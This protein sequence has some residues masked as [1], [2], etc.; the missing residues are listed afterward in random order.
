[1]PIPTFKKPEEKEKNFLEKLLYTDLDT[2]TLDQAWKEYRYLKKHGINKYLEE[3][4]RAEPGFMKEWEQRSPIGKILGRAENEQI[5]KEEEIALKAE[6][7]KE[8]KEKDII[9]PTGFVKTSGTVPKFE[10]KDEYTLGDEDLSEVGLGES[11]GHAIASFTIKIPLGFANLAAEISDLF[12]EEGLPVDQ[13]NVAKLNSW[14]ERTVL[15]DMM[16]YSEKKA[17]A[18]ATGRITEALGQLLGAYKTAG[19]TGIKIY[20]KGGEIAD[21]MIDAY[22]KKKYIKATGK[23]GKNMYK[24]AKKAKQLKKASYGRDFGAVAFGGLTTAAGIYDI[25]DIGT[26]GDIFFDEGEWTALDRREGEDADDDAARRLWNRLRFG[27]ELAFP[28][29]PIVYGGGKVAKMLATRGKDLAYSNSL[30]ERWV[31]KW[32]GQP[33]RARSKKPLEVAR[34]VRRQEGKEASARVLAED[35]LLDI[36][37]KTKAILKTIKPAAEGVEN[38]ELISKTLAKLLASGDD[39][40]TRGGINFKGFKNKDLETFYKSMDNLGI[41]KKPAKDLAS[42]LMGIRQSFTGFKNSILQGKNIAK[43]TSE[44]NEIMM[45][46]FTDNLTTDFRIFT[47]KPLMWI[48][49]FKPSREVK[50]EVAQIFLR[51]A[52]ANGAKGYNLQDAMMEVDYILK[53]AKMNPITRTPEF[54]FKP[55]SALSD[56]SVQTKNI[57]SN[58]KGGKFVPD[59][60]GLITKQSDLESFKKLFGSYQNANQVI[61]NTMSDFA[62]MASKNTMYNNIKMASEAMIKNG[63]RGIVYNNWDEARKAFPNKEIINQPLNLKIADGLPDGLYR[64]PIDGMWT[65]KEVSD[66]LKLIDDQA[67]GSISKNMAYRWLVMIPKGAGQVGKTVLGPFTHSRNFFSGAVTAVANGNILIPPGELIKNM[68]VALRTIQPQTMYRITGNP[69]WRNIRGVNTSDPS[70]LVDLDTGGQ[71][72]YRFLLDEGVVNS[73]ATY[74]DVLGLLKDIQKGGDFLS[75]VFDKM[76]KRT[77]AMLR[78]SQD[79]YVAEDDIWKIFNFFGESYKLNRAFTNALSAGK[80][81]K[82]QMPT[83]LEMYRESARIVRNTIPNYSYVSNFVQGA[84][85]SP[86][87]NFVSF[88]AEI[89]RTTANMAEEGLSQARNVTPFL[90]KYGIKE[91]ILARNGYERLF[92]LGFTL[93]ALPTMA[94]HGAKALYGVSRDKV[95]AIREMVAP[96]S[97][98]STLLPYVNEDGS[99]GY[100]DFSHGFFYDTV[101]NPVQSIVNSVHANQDQPLVTG[102]AE[103]M[104]RALGRLV[105]PFVSESIWMGVAM[106]ILVR[107]GV[108][109]QGKRIF[110]EREPLGDKIWKSVKHASYTMSPG[111]L[112]QLTRLYKA[113][114]GETIKGQ[115]YEIPKEL[116]GFFGFRGVD[117]NPPRTLDFKI[118]DYN[119]D[120]RAERNLIYMGTLTGDPV[121]DNDKIVRQFIL[122]NQQHLETMSKIKRVVDAAQVLGMRDKE[123]RQQFEDRGLGSLYK[124]YLRKNKFQ[125]FNITEGMEKAYKDVAEENNIPNPLNKDVKKRIKKIRKQLKKQRLN[126]DYI[127]KE[128]DWVAG[129]S[130]PGQTRTAQAPLP[131]TPGVNPQLV[132]QQGTT[133]G[134]N[135]SPRTGL[136]QTETALLSNE[137]KAMRLRQRGMA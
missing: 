115:R 18:T 113:A 39:V 51:N 9:Q 22:K 107:N 16:K 59:K 74:R 25:E 112:P 117:L 83:Q 1:M 15:G 58:I 95:Q 124:Q 12:A 97:V 14:F 76:G 66:A 94:Y 120:K 17:R 116:A 85:R 8:R 126:S 99:Y 5:K 71:A 2:K 125:P 128:S 52:R 53:T 84:R 57:A 23:E 10:V 135:I 44:F 34:E 134:Q 103:G 4:E 70:K 101:T 32:I 119:R 73:S 64:S 130:V 81:T 31:D 108:T 26:F 67:L 75:R 100:V 111:S 110:N 28:I 35:F 3:K 136:T 118:Q 137:E 46:R 43:G 89:M 42:T 109:R 106:D 61:T 54:S 20:N 21:N 90:A 60:D 91:N 68:Q 6:A 77:K 78:W 131:A 63:E 27:S 36:D 96:W 47:D 123:I 104:V 105:D 88:P 13:S 92:G 72:L 127:I 19:K 87:G 40:V 82:A 114:M 93:A 48:N 102:L 50:E 29:M 122:A 98:D 129:L 62:S 55:Q 45:K 41:D 132:A 65:T 56:V 49:G 86:L 80:I 79:M 133:G 37:D 7:S 11:V 121:T 38:S 30:F 69:K 24:A 33:F